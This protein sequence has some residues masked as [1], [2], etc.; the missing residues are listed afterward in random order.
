[1]EYCLSRPFKYV[2]Q[3]FGTCSLK[4]SFKH[5]VEFVM[6]YVDIF[7]VK[8]LGLKSN[9]FM[10]S[11][12]FSRGFQCSKIPSLLCNNERPFPFDV[13]INMVFFNKI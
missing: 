10:H 8:L 3:T 9:N 2:V 12:F 4:H 13:I 5:L 7:E 6:F 11:K 1:M